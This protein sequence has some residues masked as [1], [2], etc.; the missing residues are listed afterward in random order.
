[1]TVA[2]STLIN[3]EATPYYH[4]ISRCVRRSFLCGFDEYSRKCFE[5]RRGWI[6]K[7]LILLAQ[8]FCIDVCAYAIMSNHYHL[9]LHINTKN[10]D[11]LSYIEVAER[12]LSLHRAP[13]LIT[14]FLSGEPLSSAEKARSIE[15][16]EHWRKRL[17]SIS[18]FMK[19]LNQY[20]AAEANREEGCTGH[21]WEGRF[22]SQALLDEKALA[23]AM[24]YVDLNPIRASVADTPESSDFTSVKERI[25]ALR[26][27]QQTAPFLFPFVGYSRKSIPEGLPFR[28]LDYLEL[29]DWSARQIRGDNKGHLEQV[30]PPILQRIGLEGGSLLNIFQQIENWPMFGTTESLKVSLPLFNRQRISGLCLPSH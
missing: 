3:V 4:C 26:N 24:A 5:H 29:I 9:V 19:L 27:D 13:A 6:E 23:A 17:V 14:R 12:W 16:I 28:L 7:R 15:I 2:R 8:S 22:K 20:I 25:L 30:L 1:M 18:W 10:A 21:F 11:K